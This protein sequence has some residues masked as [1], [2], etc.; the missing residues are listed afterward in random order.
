MNTTE[1]AGLSENTNIYD[2]G[3]AQVKEHFCKLKP[4]GHVKKHQKAL[5]KPRASL[6]KKIKEVYKKVIKNVLNRAKF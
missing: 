1:R 2:G 3:D 4:Q 5:D 6:L